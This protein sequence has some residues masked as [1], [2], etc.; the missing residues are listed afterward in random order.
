VCEVARRLG[1]ADAF[2]FRSPAEIFRE[3]AALSAFENNHRR[4]FDIGGLAEISDESY[5][6]LDPVQWPVRSANDR[7]DTR[8]F[9][10]GGFFTTTGK[11]RFV[12][13]APPSLRSAISAAFP[14]RL[15]T[16]R[17][18]DQWHTMTRTGLS[19]RLG[20][21]ASEP[22][23]E[24]HPDDAHAAG[25]ADGDLA[26]ASTAHGACVLKVVVSEGQR[27]GALFAPIHWSGETASCARVGALVDPHTDPHSGQPE[28]K[29]TPAAIARA[30][31]RYRGFL[32]TR[33]SA[34]L[35]LETWW[36]RVAVAGGAGLLIASNE[37]PSAWRQHVHAMMREN[38]EAAEFLDAQGGVYRAAAFIE[39]R[40]DLCLF[41]GPASAAPRWDA[42]KAVLESEAIEDAHRRVLLS[43]RNVDGLAAQGPLVCACFGVGLTA[44]R[45][46][47]A[48]RTATSVDEIRQALRAG[49]NCG[50]CLPELKRIVAH[51]RLAQPV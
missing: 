50:S 18:R 28:A 44:I 47:I 43:G 11:A 10:A 14:L 1:F 48:A 12:P 2:A 7:S 21:H 19:P 34:T 32:L 22:F 45:D 23:V 42:V 33:R 26:R 16:G 37:A 39:G 9:A 25:L 5:D 51:E 30:S 15:N 46:A 29:A 35:P 38:T 20:A 24:I 6:R 17:V 13:V 4:D 31:F 27:R 41:V 36:T 49:S 40:L 8:F 3:H